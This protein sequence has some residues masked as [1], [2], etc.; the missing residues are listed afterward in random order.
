VSASSPQLSSD[1]LPIGQILVRLLHRFRLELFAD[2]Q[3]G[4]DFPGIRF[5]HLAVW[6]N[7]G[8]KGI[9]LTELADRAT[10]SMAACS[11]LVNE[12]EDLGYLERRPDPSDGRAKLIHP[13]AEGRRL[14]RAARQEVAAMEQRWRQL[15]PN[16][17]FDHACQAF[18]RLI[19]ALVPDDV[20]D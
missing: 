17:D 3:R 6:G 4:W 10:L 9:R 20:T 12:L 19:H 2:G 11:E 16:G 5:A 7:V 14:L 18:D 1:R 15:L 13:T 8:V